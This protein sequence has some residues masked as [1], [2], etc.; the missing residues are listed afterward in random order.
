MAKIHH[1]VILID[2]YFVLF[3]ILLSAIRCEA[4]R[5]PSNGEITY[6]KSPEKNRVDWNEHANYTC[7]QGFVLAGNMTRTCGY[8]RT[9][10]GF[11]QWGPDREPS[12]VGE[13]RSKK[14][15]SR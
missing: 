11:G 7:H 4:L 5:Q 3:F 1:V 15:D 10:G 6:S 9:D 14:K 12:C 8:S 2:S 13:Y